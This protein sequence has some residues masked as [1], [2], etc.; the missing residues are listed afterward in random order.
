VFESAFASAALHAELQRYPQ[1]TPRDRRLVTELVYG[2]LRVWNFLHA[3]LAALAP[4]GIDKQDP[5]TAAHLHVAAYQIVFLSGIPARAAVHCAVGAIRRQRSPALAAFANGLLRNLARRM[6]A[7][8]RPAVADAVLQG[9]PAWLITALD[10][11]LGSGQSAAFLTQGPSPPPLGLR[12]RDPAARERWMATIREELPDIEIS[13]GLLSAYC[14]L[15]HR[16]GGDPRHV[17][18]VATGGLWVQEQ[19]SQGVVEKL[20]AQPGEIVLD[21]CAGYGNKSL[22]LAA[23]TQ[24]GGRVDSADLYPEKLTQLRERAQ[25]L[26]LP[27]GATYGVDWSQGTGDVPIDHYD[28]VLVDAPCSGVGTVAR[29]PEIPLRRDAGS[30]QNLHTLQVTILAHAAKTVRPGGTLLYAVC[31][32]LREE[33]EDVVAT[34]PNFRLLSVERFTPHHD[35]TDGYAMARLV[36]CL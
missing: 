15:V 18:G 36:R 7:A 17:P 2:T 26:H 28:R 34:L 27:L 22:A 16:G 29:R 21:A 31:S 5:Q 1:L 14:L 8:P 6:E 4:R 35:G 13:A 12:A 11:A 3:Q 19:G 30:V 32:V 25:A 10:H 24:P 33:A 23:L 20:G 9:A